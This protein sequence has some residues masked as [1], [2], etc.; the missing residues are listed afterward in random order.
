MR[1]GSTLILL[2][3]LISVAAPVRASGASPAIEQM[4]IAGKE[5]ARLSDCA[6]ANDF[7]SRW[8]KRDETIELSN[9]A[10]RIQLPIHSPEAQIDGV[11]VRLLFPLVQ[12]G[13]SVWMALLDLKSTFEPVLSPPR[14]RRGAALKTVCLDPGHG[15][16]DPGFQVGSSKEKKFTLLFSQE[17]QSQLKRAG[18]NVSLTRSRDTFVELPTRPDIARTSLP[19]PGS[20]IAIA[21]ISVPATIG[22]SQRRRCSSVPYLRM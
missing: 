16:K 4:R 13:E 11:E 2:V 14:L 19:A 21:P 5:Y 15:G 8:L 9:Y 22:G 7:I 17:L 1:L 3:L 12:K 10:H 20:V 18:W 6:R